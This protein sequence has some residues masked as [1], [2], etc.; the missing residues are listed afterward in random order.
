MSCLQFLVGFSNVSNW[1]VSILSGQ[2]SPLSGIKKIVLP[3]ILF[4]LITNLTIL[5]SPIFMMQV[6]DRVV[7]SGNIQTLLLLLGLATGALIANGFVDYSRDLALS[8]TSRWVEEI[9][10]PNLLT[11]SANDRQPYL[12]QVLVL[13]QFLGGPAAISALSV[14]WIPLF[15]VALI[16]IHPLFLLLA[17]VV[18]AL[19]LGIKLIGNALMDEKNQTCAQLAQ[20]GAKVI[21]DSNQNLGLTGLVAV[22]RNLASKMQRLMQTRHQIEGD[23]ASKTAIIS[24][25][26][27][28]IRMFV[29]LSGLALG[30]FLVVQGQISAGA[31]IGASLI[32]AKTIGIF[33]QLTTHF[34]IIQNFRTAFAV[35]RQTA[36]TASAEGTEIEKLSGALVAKDL[37]F[38]RGGGAPPRLDRIS[39]DLAAG[40]CLA[41][42]GDSGSGKTTLLQALSGLDPSPIGAVF[43]DE[44]DVRTLGPSPQSRNI[45]YL[46]QRASLLDGTIAENI[47]CFDPDASDERIINA[48]K[49]AGVHGMISAL[50]ASYET[51]MG[52]HGF[53]LSAGQK[54]R[55]ALA[56]TIFQEPRYLFLDEP[57]ALLDAQSE[58]QLGQTLSKLKSRGTTV[59]M[60]L[61]RSCIMNLADKVLFLNQGLVSDFGPRAAVLGRL[62]Q[63]KRRLQIPINAEGLMDLSDWVGAQFTRDGDEEF[64]QPAT[65]V[66]SE[67]FNAAREN[68][69][70]DNT[71]IIAMTFNFVDDTHCK[72]SL[73]DDRPTELDQKMP[74]IMS[75]VKHPNV[76]MEDIPPDEMALVIV[77]QLSE[78]L[79]VKNHEKSSIFSAK[80]AQNHS[81]SATSSSR[82]H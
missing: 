30:A 41:I 24:A 50:P 40:D 51:N 33:E 1:D 63:N 74:K 44:T 23:V 64:K 18:S 16:L 53:L 3:L 25:T 54:Q 36:I 62:G 43:L 26:S 37:T 32:N 7:P 80:L 45:G 60:V 76:S 17:L 57:N 49:L 73:S 48:S 20:Q 31:M 56:R 8:R 12:D 70:I 14:P 21:S 68:G 71:R 82:Q 6:L 81:F 58:R 4:S 65:L 11:L 67:M 77:A 34:P 28:S 2:I 19:N 79:E 29:Q 72:I 66:A 78:S 27:G 22:E 10:L 61:H 69:V 15:L 42:V 38:P 13:R 46:P 9:T 52:S 59:V 47:A 35:L 39:L 5:I 75:L 55:V